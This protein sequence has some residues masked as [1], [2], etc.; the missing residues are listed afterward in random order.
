MSDSRANEM[1]AKIREIKRLQREVTRWLID[2]PCLDD[3]PQKEEMYRLAIDYYKT[4]REKCKN[5]GSASYNGAMSINL[6]VL[7]EC[8]QQE[9]G[10]TKQEYARKIARY[11]LD[12]TTNYWLRLIPDETK[13][14]AFQI[15]IEYLEQQMS[16]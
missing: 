13:E 5:H 15:I 6:A 1:K 9:E 11:M 12:E 4:K 7:I 2:N 10:S 3:N 16:S 8:Y 14:A